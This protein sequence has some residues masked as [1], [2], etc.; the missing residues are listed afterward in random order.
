MADMYWSCD[1]CHAKDAEIER[2][3]ARM[4]RL[5]VALASCLPFIDDADDVY[6]FVADSAATPAC[7]EAV[8]KARAALREGE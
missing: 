6:E 1:A 8:Q 4:A 2:L 7:R 5:T 3:R